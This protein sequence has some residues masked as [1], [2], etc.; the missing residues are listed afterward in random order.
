L[1][2]K[3]VAQIVQRRGSDTEIVCFGGDVNARLEQFL[4]LCRPTREP[5]GIAETGGNGRDQGRLICLLGQLQ[6]PV[7]L[8]K[9]IRMSP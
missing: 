4:G 9:R 3:Q 1:P 6:C 2:G 5:V 8:L 7:Q